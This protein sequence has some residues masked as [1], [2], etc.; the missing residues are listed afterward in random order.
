MRVLRV[1]APVFGARVFECGMCFFL[2]LTFILLTVASTYYSP[3]KK[4]ATVDSP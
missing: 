1:L 3:M 2:E 4:E